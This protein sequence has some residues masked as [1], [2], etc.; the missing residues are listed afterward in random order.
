MFFLNLYI[1]IFASRNHL[2]MFGFSDIVNLLNSAPGTAVYLRKLQWTLIK[3]IKH[4]WKQ[5][6]MARLMQQMHF[7]VTFP[8]C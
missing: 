6:K 2:H 7:Y 4:L 3:E 5:A 8:F 1:L